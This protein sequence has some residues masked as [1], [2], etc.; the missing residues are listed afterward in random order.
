M[1][2][3]VVVRSRV[4]LNPKR[5]QCPLL[6]VEVIKC[7][8]R[9]EKCQSTCLAFSAILPEAP[10]VSSCSFSFLAFTSQSLHRTGPFMP[11]RDTHSSG[12]TSKNSC[13]SSET[14]RGPRWVLH[15]STRTPGSKVSQQN[16]ELS[17]DGKC[18]NVVA[19]RSIYRG[20]KRPKHVL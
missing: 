20:E 14:G 2:G 3:G 1:G 19:D 6:G 4:G 16:T 11:T 7:W 17:Q 12:V 13:D 18:H 15:M 8:F 9:G 10:A 5:L